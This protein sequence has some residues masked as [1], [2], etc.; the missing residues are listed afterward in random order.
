CVSCSSP[1]A[2]KAKMTRGS[3]DRLGVARCRPVASAVV[4]RAQMRAAFDDLSWNF[5]IGGSG[6][7]AVGL[8]A[9][10]R[11]LRNAAR[12]HGIRLM[13]RRI[14]VGGPLPDIADHVVQPVAVWRECTDRRGALETIGIGVL[15]REFPLP[16]V[17]H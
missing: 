10:A 3:I 11:V 1:D 8:A 9:A 2:S 4:R 13:L 12:L 16:G 17:C 7:V 14:P 5:H 15:A 6:V